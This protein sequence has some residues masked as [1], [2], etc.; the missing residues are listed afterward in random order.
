MPV[1]TRSTR[2]KAPAIPDP[3]SVSDEI[4]SFNDR[5]FLNPLGRIDLDIT[6]E[7][8]SHSVNSNNDYYK[9]LNYIKK[10]KFTFTDEDNEINSG[11]VHKCCSRNKCLLCNN[12]KPSDNF[13]STMTHRTYQTKS[14]DG[15]KILDCSTVN[16]IYLISCSRCGLQYVGETVQSLR[17]RFRTHRA[18]I[19]KPFS[20]NQCKILS[21]HFGSGH[22]K[23]ANYQVQI[24]EKLEG[25]GRDTNGKPLPGVTSQ[26]QKTET[27]WM[28]KLQ[29]VYPFGLNDRIGDEYMTE[30][31]CKVVSKKFLPLHRA[32]NRPPYNV[33]RTK[34]DNSFLKE[35]FLK[36]LQ[37][38]LDVNIKDAGFFIR[39][40]IKSFKKSALKF[41]ST[42]I[43]DFV[44]NKPN[45]FPNHQW[46]NMALDLIESRIYKPF[47][48][49]KTKTI[50]KHMIKI[51]F[52]NKGI[53][54][55][56]I[57]KILN[58]KNV[59][60]TLP[61]LFDKSDKISTI[62]K[63]SNT[64]RSKIYNHKSFLQNLDT[65]EIIKKQNDLPCDCNDSPFKDPNHGHIVT[66]DLRIV[67]NN[68]LRKLLCKGPKY[69]EP[70]PINW[71]KCR[72]EIKNGI[73][74]FYNNYCNKKGLS[75]DMFLE[76]ANLVMSKV[77]EKIKDLKKNTKF[78]TV[79]Q[80]LKDPNVT[81][82][83]KE[84][85]S[86][87]VMSPIDK[88]A[89]N[90]AFICKKY[91][92]DV[93]LKELGIASIPSNTYKIINKPVSDI[94]DEQ[95]NVL[96]NVFNI[97]NKDEEDN[98]LPTIYWLPKMHKNPSGARFIIA[99]KKCINKKLTQYITS[100][101]KL[102]F[103]QFESY[104]KKMHYHTWTKTFWVIQ[105]NNSP[106]ESIQKINKRNNAKQISTFDF[107]TLYTKIP[108][109]ELLEVLYNIVDFVF[110]GGTRDVISIDRLGNPSWSTCKKGHTYY[111]TKSSLK[112]AITFI[113]RNCYFSFG[114]ISLRQIIGIPMGSDPAPFFANLFLA[115]YEI[116]WINDQR[117]LGVINTR[118]LNNTFRFIDDLLS[119]N[120]DSIFESS[121]NS[122]YPTEME[123]KKE[124]STNNAATF[125][126]IN[127]SIENGKF[128]TKLFDKRDNFGFDIVRMPFVSSNM[129]G[130]MF[131]GSI[132]AEFLR[133]ARATSKIEDLSFTCK[134]LL[135]RMSSQGS[136]RNKTKS[137]LTKMIQRHWDSFKKYEISIN[138]ILNKVGF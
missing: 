95:K 29:T 44:S 54:M 129:P 41:I 130:K 10:S 70:V 120:D 26:R 53:D 36:I 123:L 68:K 49:G 34:L 69:R 55:I 16:C 58:E 73:S 121:Y 81:T 30:K 1:Q 17:A 96:K 76:W 131:Y 75:N 46:Y 52:V 13:Y 104:H 72:S 37:T 57:G 94:L 134:Q 79:K 74:T 18:G 138:E 136:R 48:S 124:N 97:K 111:F 137:V 45:D 98:C 35:N 20:N 51:N 43:Y 127:I 50:P 107:S 80:V 3:D 42:N 132:G 82:Y 110:K 56:N 83:L 106:L 122:I 63:L 24:I 12:L 114:N 125:L 87:Y 28:L 126:D 7:G 101:F 2:V 117:K 62:Y 99:G 4:V 22:C 9:I 112:E 93:I 89:N 38:H 33:N 15:N 102:C 59:V 66:G 90:T 67:Q 92:V 118:K 113:L 21:R 116:R 65:A 14:H 84:L 23:G 103:N 108:H 86:K 64:I 5:S 60:N 6:P 39:V 71:E 85:Q 119:L 105:N 135:T 25:S 78:T 27:N 31:E 61:S 91:Y 47:S 88:A 115:F 128:C 8:S 11:L 133:I 77:D 19:K 100:V 109:D 40:S 32:H